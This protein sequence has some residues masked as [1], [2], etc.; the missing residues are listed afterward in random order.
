MDSNHN[1]RRRGHGDNGNVNGDIVE[2]VT[3][4]R[5]SADTADHVEGWVLHR[6]LGGLSREDRRQDREAGLVHR[7]AVCSPWRKPN[8][9]HGCT[10]ARWPHGLPCE[11]PR[12][13]LAEV[14]ARSIERVARLYNFGQG[15]HDP[16]SS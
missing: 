9:L 4:P 15:G 7:E 16:L 10:L 11:F 6:A 3:S 1:G 2:T 12:V 14:A 8:G 13:G 5:A